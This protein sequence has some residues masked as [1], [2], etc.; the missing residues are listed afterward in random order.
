M[1]FN[2]LL[3]CREQPSLR[4]L[5]AALEGLEVEQEVCLSAPEAV[6]LMTPGRYSALV[7]DFD[8]PGAAQVARMARLAPPHQRPVVFAMIGAQTGIAGAF[9]AGA[10]FVL[11]KPLILEQV[12]RSL[13]AGRVFMQPDRRRSQRQRLEGLVYLQFGVAAVPALVLDLS[14]QGLS[15][16]APEPLPAV[17]KVPLRFVLPG[18]TH[19]VE[20][21]G[22]L[23]WADDEGRAGMLFSRLTPTSRKYLKTWLSKRSPRKK[24]AVHG[25][26]RSEK[27]RSAQA[28]H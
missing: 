12:T 13:R 2:C 6:E 3:M 22:E 27:A 15:L 1:K 20:G 14:E 11:Y 16:Q 28:S 5:A 10:N 17:Q 9:Q 8:L 19:M 18:T 7:L 25:A 21:N 26:S 24:S 4:V 23:I